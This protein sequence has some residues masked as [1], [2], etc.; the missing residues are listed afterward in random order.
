MINPPTASKLTITHKNLEIP[1]ETSKAFADATLA[2]LV[3]IDTHENHPIF[4]LIAPQFQAVAVREIEQQPGVA[5]P[6][7][8]TATFMLVDIANAFKAMTYDFPQETASAFA[9]AASEAERRV[10]RNS[11]AIQ[12]WGGAVAV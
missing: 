6:L 3:Q 7:V 12:R 10:R 4:R 11:C 5:I 2:A 9:K 1:L 8:H